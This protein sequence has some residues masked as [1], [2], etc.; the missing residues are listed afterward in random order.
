MTAMTNEPG[1][2]ARIRAAAGVVFERAGLEGLTMRA[3]AREVGV[4]ATALYRHYPNRDAILQEV[5]R[6]GYEDLTSR[7]GE[8]IDA[9]GVTDRILVLLDRYLV[10]AIGLSEIYELKHRYD[11]QDRDLLKRSAGGGVQ[12]GSHDSLMVLAGELQGAMERGELADH[13]IWTMALA[14]WALGNGLVSLYRAGQVSLDES[15]LRSS[16]RECMTALLRGYSR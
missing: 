10:W 15:R 4:T 9:E 5:W 7:M 1:T 14:I 12:Q 11:P 3:I 16:A 8:P 2:K 6:L 13:D